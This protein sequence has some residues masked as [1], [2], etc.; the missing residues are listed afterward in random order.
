MFRRRARSLPEEGWS[1]C[2]ATQGSQCRRRARGSPTTS[3]ARSTLVRRENGPSLPTA[4]LHQRC[5]QGNAYG[6]TGASL[7]RTSCQLPGELALVSNSRAVPTAEMAASSQ[8]LAL[9]W[10]ELTLVTS[11]M[12]PKEPAGMDAKQGGRVLEI[13]RL[14]AEPRWWCRRQRSRASRGEITKGFTLVRLEI[15]L[16]AKISP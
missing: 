7:P 9:V 15:N 8:E 6:R 12:F 1:T 3:R 4:E 10:A 14:A 16:I 2:W 5:S 13:S 11:T